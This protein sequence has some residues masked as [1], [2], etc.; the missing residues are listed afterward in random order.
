[1]LFPN[2]FLAAV[3]VTT[4]YAGP[5]KPLTG[6]PSSL[7]PS[8]ITLSFSTSSSETSNPGDSATSEGFDSQEVTS[9]STLA[10][11]TAT[12]RDIPTTDITTPTIVASSLE[13]VDS[14]V[15]SLGS[16]TLET[17]ATDAIPI[18]TTVKG[19]IEAPT[20]ETSVE[21]TASLLTSTA[22]ETTSITSETTTAAFCARSTTVI[23]ELE[24][25]RDAIPFCVQYLS[26][27]TH[28]VTEYETLQP[29]SVFDY[30]LITVTADA[31]TKIKTAYEG[32]TAIETAKETKTEWDTTTVTS[33]RS[34]DTISCLDS[35][36]T[37][38]PP[39]PTFEPARGALG[40]RGESLEVVPVA[41]PN[42][43]TEAETSL[44]C[45]CLSLEAPST[46][47]TIFQTSEPATMV[48][49]S[50]DVVTPIETYNEI[51]TTTSVSTSTSTVTEKRTVTSTAWIVETTFAYNNNMAYRRYS[52]TFNA[53]V[54]NNG[55]TTTWF[56]SQTPLFSGYT[57]T[58]TFA[59]RGTF[60]LSNGDSFDSGPAALLYN[61]YFYAKETGKYKF[62]IAETIDNWGYLWVND[63][64]YTWNQGAWAIEGRRTGSDPTLWKSGSYEINLNKGD[65]IPFTYLWAN[66]GGRGNNDMTVIAPSGRSIPGMQGSTV[67]ACNRG[68]FQ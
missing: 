31:V 17:T 2:L 19:A 51:I 46:T 48:V 8:E 43:W 36:Y 13:S 3:A 7:S 35:A 47:T 42:E 20:S 6:K 63:A 56:K 59:S 52:S 5:C 4:A 50:T 21:D 68:R 53:Y 39:V 44:A 15:S 37:Y 57:T 28:T 67:Q 65:A 25:D 34:I 54:F 16:T 61:A 24:D 58:F 60:T 40:E 12:S 18:E 45:E 66:G 38:T 1:M 32:V 27:A 29:S 62:S 41:F 9:K 33:T 26:I 55:F 64:A 49:A 11:D 22:A 23:S 30:E 14:H 10:I